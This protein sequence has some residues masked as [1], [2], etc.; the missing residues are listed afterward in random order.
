MAGLW[1]CFTHITK[2]L[3]TI[4]VTK[5]GGLIM[6]DD[7]KSHGFFWLIFILN[8]L[9]KKKVNNIVYY[10]ISSHMF[11]WVVKNSLKVPLPPALDGDD[12]GVAELDGHLTLRAAQ[13]KPAGMLR[14][15]LTFNEIIG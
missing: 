4:L 11:F 15:S 5:N 14:G 12:H 13:P 2:I 1:H 3:M 6:I 7:R 8:P 10:Y 9:L